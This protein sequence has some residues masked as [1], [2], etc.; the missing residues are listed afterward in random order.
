MTEKVKRERSLLRYSAT[1][2]NEPKISGQSFPMTLL[3]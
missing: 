3:R 1:H 2:I